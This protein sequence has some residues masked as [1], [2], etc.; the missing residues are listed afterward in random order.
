MVYKTASTSNSLLSSSLLLFSPPVS[1][2]RL[3]ALRRSAPTRSRFVLRLSVPFTRKQEHPNYCLKLAA[4]S[5]VT[6]FGERS[7]G[8]SAPASARSLSARWAD[9]LRLRFFLGGGSATP[10]SWT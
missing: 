2:H 3:P 7:A 6:L 8:K 4:P 1:R 10:P 9:L 5:A